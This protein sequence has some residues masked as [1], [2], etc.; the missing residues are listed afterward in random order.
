M[1]TLTIVPGLLVVNIMKFDFEGS[2]LEY[3]TLEVKAFCL[4]PDSI[5]QD[6]GT[7]TL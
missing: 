2:F 7:L 3:F 5:V 1:L 4:L 6:F